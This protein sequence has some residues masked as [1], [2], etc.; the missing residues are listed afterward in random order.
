LTRKFSVSIGL[1]QDAQ[2]TSA[3]IV[4]SA[5]VSLFGT[6]GLVLAAPLT[7]AAVHISS[8][9]ARARAIEGR[10]SAEAPGPPGGTAAP[11]IVIG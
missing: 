1:R 8:D 7:S 3:L 2:P 10:G 6:I 9:L 5:G 4:T 11:P